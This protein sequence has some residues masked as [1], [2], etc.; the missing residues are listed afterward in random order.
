MSTTVSN[1]LEIGQI[2][3]LKSGEMKKV[4]KMGYEILLARVGDTYYASEDRC[5]HMGGDLSQGKLEGTIVTCP[6]HG[7]QYDLQNGHVVRWTTWPGALV[8]IDQIRSRKRP[9]PVYPVTISDDKI[10]IKL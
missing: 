10:M 6:L 2:N 3:D 7:S 5:R 4:M 9:L 8:A 1:M